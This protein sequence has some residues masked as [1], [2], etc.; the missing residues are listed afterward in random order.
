MSKVSLIAAT[1]ISISV[2][3]TTWMGH[4]VLAQSSKT[5]PDIASAVP[6]TATKV[7]RQDVPI[8]LEDWAPFS[9]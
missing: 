7:Q 5:K 6:V 8:V 2:A 1:C 4:A 3:L 9:R